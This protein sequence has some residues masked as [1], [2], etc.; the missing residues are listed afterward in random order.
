MRPAADRGSASLLAVVMFPVLFLAV[1]LVFDGGQVLATR[2]EVIGDAE[3][4]AR[5]A[6]DE[7]D[8]FSGVLDQGTAETVARAVAVARA[9]ERVVAVRVVGRRVEVVLAATAHEVFFPMFGLEPATVIET[10]SAEV[11]R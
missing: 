3:S 6:A 8:P 4:A 5:L 2:R 9:G 7:A 11:R 10:G 1:G